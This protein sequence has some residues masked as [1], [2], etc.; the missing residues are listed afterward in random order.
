MTISF[1]AFLMEHFA[2]TYSHTDDLLQEQ[3]ESWIQG[4]DVQDIIDLAEKWDGGHKPSGNYE[5]PGKKETTENLAKLT[6]RKEKL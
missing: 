3:Y 6:I 2:R 1:E 4:C 5:M